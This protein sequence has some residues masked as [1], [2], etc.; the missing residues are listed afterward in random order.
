MCQQHR[1]H[2]TQSMPCTEFTAHTVHCTQS[3]LHT[4]HTAHTMCTAHYKYCIQGQHLQYLK[5]KRCRT[6]H[7]IHVMCEVGYDCLQLQPLL[8]CRTVTALTPWTPTVHS[9]S[10]VE[11]ARPVRLPAMVRPTAHTL[12]RLR[13]GHCHRRRAALSSHQH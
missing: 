4:Q 2:S 11:E 7:E 10:C 5:P 13:P 12:E 1:A 6:A 8:S 3:I 9:L